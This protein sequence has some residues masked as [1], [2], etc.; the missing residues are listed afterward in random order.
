M[1]VQGPENELLITRILRAGDSYRVPNRIGLTMITG[2]AGALEI[3][4][5]GLVV[6]SVGPTGAVRRNIAL[7]PDK[8]LA[9]SNSTE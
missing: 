8:L 4:V 7:D 2:N 9:S 5:G 1:Q 6:N 3:T